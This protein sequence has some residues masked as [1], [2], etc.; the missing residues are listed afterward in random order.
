[1]FVRS[2]GACVLRGG[3]RFCLPVLPYVARACVCAGVCLVPG[4]CVCYDC[5]PR[6]PQ[7]LVESEVL[8][9][10]PE[11]VRLPFL[12]RLASEWLCGKAYKLAYRGSRDGMTPLAFHTACDGRGA[13][14]TLV[15]CSGGEVFGGYAASAWGGSGGYISSPLSFVFTVCGPAGTRLFPLSPSAASKALYSYPGYGPCFDG[16]FRLRGR[17]GQGEEAY[18][19]HS[20][21]DMGF[22]AYDDVTG[23]AEEALTGTR[24][25]TPVEVEIFLILTQDA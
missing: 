3:A 9:Q 5:V 24:T 14:L 15:R 12:H 6:L 7:L 8:C 19:S 4:R 11:C 2:L 10:L 25:F 22:G 23:L 1:M 20:C 18:D 17:R 16:G 21:C 13:T